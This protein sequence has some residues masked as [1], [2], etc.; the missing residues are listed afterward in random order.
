[1][2][3]QV[4]CCLVEAGAARGSPIA[5]GREDSHFFLLPTSPPAGNFLRVSK[6]GSGAGSLFSPLR[7]SLT[8]SSTF[9]T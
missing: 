3:T 6:W 7:H 2:E 5:V 8:R 9:K 1:V 4:W